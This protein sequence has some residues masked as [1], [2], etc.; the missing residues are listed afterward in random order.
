MNFE[1]NIQFQSSPNF[2]Y[3]PIQNDQNVPMMIPMQNMNHI[4]QQNVQPTIIYTTNPSSIG[5]I[6]QQTYIPIQQMPQIQQQEAIIVQDQLPIGNRHAPTQANLALVFSI[7]SFFVCWPLCFVGLILAKNSLKKIGND[8]THPDY[9]AA[10]FAYVISIS[11]I[12]IGLCLLIF[13]I[14]YVLFVLPHFHKYGSR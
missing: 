14:A 1:N 12:T 10:R 7:I 11:S 8:K 13:A 4:P 5:Y 6:P 9:R 2:Y 3:H